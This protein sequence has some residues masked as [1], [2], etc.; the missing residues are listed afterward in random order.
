[1]TITVATKQ[2]VEVLTDALRT[3]NDKG[4]HIATY[5]APYKD[6]PGNVDLLA[7]TSSTGYVLGHT[8]IR[9]D[10]QLRY[11]S[12]WPVSSTASVRAICKSLAKKGDKNNEHTVDIDMVMADLPDDAEPGDHPGWT[13]TLSETPALFDS[14]TEFQFHASD[15]SVFPINTVRRLLAGGAE[16]GRAPTLQT[17][18]GS[19]VLEPLVKISARRS[20]PMEFYRAED[21][22]LQRVQIG[23]TWLGAA[24]PRTPSPGE[25]TDEPTIES[26]LGEAE[27]VT[28]LQG[29]K[30]D[31]VTV[32]VEN[33]RGPLA[34]TIADAVNEVN[35]SHVD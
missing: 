29:M 8:W 12:V 19:G 17:T 4:V 33:P 31:G 15:E 22:L 32:T 35:E 20:A 30:A 34:Q 27:L 25:A 18:W 21:R 16:A 2:L 14:D 23:D 6:E 10:G 24:M 28:I 3:S 9:C 7:V 13:V 1:M 26:V 5:R 11:P